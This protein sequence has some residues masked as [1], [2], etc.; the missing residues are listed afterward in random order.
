MSEFALWV[1][2]HFWVTGLSNLFMNYLPIAAVGALYVSGCQRRGGFVFRLCACVLLCALNI[3]LFVLAE[4]AARLYLQ[5][6]Y[7]P[8]ALLGFCAM[9][10]F[11]S[12][13][14]WFCCRISFLEA[15]SCAAIGYT[16]QN[17]AWKVYAFFLHAFDAFEAVKENSLLFWGVMLAVSGAGVFVLWL[18][19][20]ARCGR[21]A[22]EVRVAQDGKTFAFVIAVLAVVIVLSYVCDVYYRQDKVLYLSSCLLFALT[23]PAVRLDVRLYLCRAVRQGAAVAERRDAAPAREDARTG[24]AAVR[25]AARKRFR[26]QFEVPRSE[27]S[28]APPEGGARGRGRRPL[29]RQAIRGFEVDPATG[30]EAVDTAVAEKWMLCNAKGISFSCVVDG[31]ALSFMEEGDLFSLFG[32]A[33]DNAVEASAAMEEG[34]RVV[35]VTTCRRGNFLVLQFQN[36]YRGELLFCGGLPLSTKKEKEYH[37]FGTASIRA[38]VQKYGG[39]LAIDAGGGIYRLD[40]AF[41]LPGQAAEG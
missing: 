7:I 31:K 35:S 38:I 1:Q 18:I 34:K 15:L 19:H 10:L 27:A 23:C 9:Y 26:H 24:A 11:I 29:H 28:A 36:Y 17:M 33:L 25:T 16:L 20:A 6:Y 4:L 12:F 22:R 2:Q 41:P 8:V 32:N 39:S 13:A 14:L 21:A 40:I 30:N 37:G 3:S 5:A